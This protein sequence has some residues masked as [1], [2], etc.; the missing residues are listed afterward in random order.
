M[1]VVGVVLALALVVAGCGETRAHDAAQ[2]RKL[3]LHRGAGPMHRSTRALL[4]VTI[5]NG[6]TSRRVPGALVQIGRK[7]DRSDGH[8]VALIRVQR[9]GAYNVTVNARGYTART[10]RE[11]FQLRRKV[12]IRIYRPA[13]QWPMYGVSAARS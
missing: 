8:G 1:K 4:V 11:A 2:V 13:L 3:A 5:V 7:R 6:D 10:L 12:T 9:R